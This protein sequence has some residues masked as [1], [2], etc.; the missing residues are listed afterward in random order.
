MKTSLDFEGPPDLSV[1]EI[2]IRSSTGYHRRWMATPEHRKFRGE[3]VKPGYYLT[4]ITPAGGRLQSLV[5][6]VRPDMANKVR[7]PDFAALAATGSGMDFL[8]VEDRAAAIRSIQ[9][10]IADPDEGSAN[11]PT[12]GGAERSHAADSAVAKAQSVFATPSPGSAFESATPKEAAPAASKLIS[13]A[14]AIECAGRR[15]SWRRF[16]G[17]C[18]AEVTGGRLSLEVGPPT[19]W[20]PGSARRVR[21]SL[22]IQGGRV[23]RLLLPLYRGGTTVRMTSPPLSPDDVALEILPVDPNIRAIW[24][25]LEAGAADHALAVRDDVLRVKGPEPISALEAADPWEAML[26]GL[27]F[28]RFP[29]VFGRLS[30]GWVAELVRRFPWAADVHVIHA[31]QL[32][33]DPGDTPEAMMRSSAKA[34]S[35]LARA[36]ACGSPYFKQSNMYFNELVESLSATTLAPEAQKRIERARRRW[37][38]EQE[39]QRSAGV[40]FSW[41]SRDLVAL[42]QRGVLT[43]K[44]NS[45]GRLPTR[46]AAI[47]FKGRLAAGAISFVTVERGAPKTSIGESGLFKSMPPEPPATTSQSDAGMS[48]A[49]PALARPPGPA[50]D[51][52]KGRFGG[53]ARVGGFTLSAEFGER[54]GADVTVALRVDADEGIA[55]A[56]GECV[57]LCLHPSFNPEWVRLLF[58]GRTATLTVKAWGGFTVGAWVESRQVE[59][60]CDLAELEHAPTRIRDN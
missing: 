22:A 52:N 15:D 59:L 32:A 19:G 46:N 42:R 43:P 4:E 11:E 25:A 29:E 37:Q 33:G 6:Q 57:W 55:L 40:S 39:L 54:R 28:L 26:A 34:V 18:L 47:I 31:R 38:R 20:V 48:S 36:Q 3:D 45:S 10:I 60:E 21:M 27:L 56:I 51:P 5:F 30:S 24:R 16:D 9:S 2:R 8:N 12:E 7:L 50:D 35:L 53:R 13:V 41:L 49:C 23:E 1:A 58:R 17:P 14:L 44:R